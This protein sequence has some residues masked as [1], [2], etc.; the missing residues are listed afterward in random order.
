[1]AQLNANGA[2]VSTQT[3]S[4]V[5]AARAAIAANPSL[6]FINGKTIRGSLNST[7]FAGATLTRRG[8]IN[9]SS[10]GRRPV[11]FTGAQ[12]SRFVILHEIQHG[13]GV[14]SEAEANRGALLRMGR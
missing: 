9:T 1:M 13:I 4:T 7:V 12:H 2:I 8:T 3:F 14:R 5:A 6:T 10:G 11:N